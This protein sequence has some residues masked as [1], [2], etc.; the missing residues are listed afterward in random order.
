[1]Q[2]MLCMLFLDDETLTITSTLGKKNSCVGICGWTAHES[3]LS[4]FG[5]C[6]PGV[7]R[8]TAAAPLP[9]QRGCLFVGALQKFCLVAK[10][11]CWCSASSPEQ[12]KRQFKKTNSAH[13]GESWQNC[14][15]LFFQSSSVSHRRV[16]VV[17]CVVQTD[18]HF[19]VTTQHTSVF[20]VE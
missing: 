7:E 12:Q 15:K 10:Q 11:V 2:H 19:R 6:L 13:L 20:S 5:F 9:A 8:P 14:F 18:S 4:G 17:M 3:A 1:M 16:C